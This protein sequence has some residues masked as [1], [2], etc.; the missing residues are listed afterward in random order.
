MPVWVRWDAGANHISS[1]HSER[2]VPPSL[3]SES[4][5]TIPIGTRG[6]R[7]SPRVYKLSSRGPKAEGSAFLLL[8]FAFRPFVAQGALTVFVS[9]PGDFSLCGCPNPCSPRGGMPKTHL[10]FERNVWVLKKPMMTCSETTQS[11][12]QIGAQSAPG[13]DAGAIED[14][15]HRRTAPTNRRCHAR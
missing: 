9:G 5:F 3:L 8:L 7:I 14:R 1:C 2:S 11:P 6:R 4:R 12:A 15:R 13:C 10:D